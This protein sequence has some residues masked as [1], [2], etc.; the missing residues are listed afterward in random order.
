MADNDTDE[1]ESGIVAKDDRR[2]R[3][4][5]SE[6]RWACFRKLGE[7]DR[8]GLI[9]VC[10]PK[11]ARSAARWVV[12]TLG[13]ASAFPLACT[14]V[15]TLVTG[16]TVTWAG[17]APAGRHLRSPGGTRRFAGPVEGPLGVSDGGRDEPL[18]DDGAV[19]GGLRDLEPL[20]TLCGDKGVSPAPRDCRLPRGDGPSLLPTEGAG[21]VIGMGAA[22]FPE[23]ALS[24]ASATIR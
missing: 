16:D 5:L 24:F 20:C 4:L 15:V 3:R 8:G 21:R 12:G 9:A 19:G 2:G 14:V 18:W 17:A 1:G 7:W 13:P 22:W 23:D 6:S 10:R 11:W